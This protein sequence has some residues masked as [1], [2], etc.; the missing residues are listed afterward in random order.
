MTVQS[1]I[2]YFLG[3]GAATMQKGNTGSQQRQEAVLRAAVEVF[4]K[5]GFQGATVEEIARRA[6]VA[7]GTPYLYFSD[8]AD[9]FYAVFEQWSSEIIAA[10]SPLESSA[11]SSARDRLMALALGA[12]DYMGAHREWFPL[13]MEV[14][15]ASGIPALR[16]RFS[17][18]LKELYARY[19]ETIVAI[20]HS[21]QVSGEFRKDVD[22]YA[23]AALLTGAVDGLFLQCWFDPQ[24]NAKHLLHGFFDVLLRGLA[25]PELGDRS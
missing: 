8:K 19:R 9:M 13:S 24:L 12:A 14:W 16:E 1:V 6:G 21:G 25:N 2:H 10:G 15:A 7:K 11:R 18:A 4:A 23:L 3:Y 20:V 22:P 17:E 5:R